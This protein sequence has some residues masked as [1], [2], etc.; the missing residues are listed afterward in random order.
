LNIKPSLEKMDFRA[1]GHARGHARG[2]EVE[3]SPPATEETGAIPT[4][5]GMVA[6]NKKDG[7]PILVFVFVERSSTIECYWQTLPQIWK[8]LQASNLIL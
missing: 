6:F 2:V 8:R 3:S 7:F 1:L 4:G 5:Y